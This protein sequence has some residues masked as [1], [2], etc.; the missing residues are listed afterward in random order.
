MQNDHNLLAILGPTNTG[1]TYLAFERLIAYQSG[2]FG[3]PLR[4]L[5][6]ENYDK[7]VAR[8]GIHKVALIT[9]EEKILPKEAKYYFCTVESMPLNI[10]VECIAIDEVQLAADYERGHIFTDRILHLR[11]TYETMLL[12][13]TTIQ[14]I[15]LRLF[16]NIKIENR[17]RFSRLSFSPKRNLSK[18]KPRSAVIAF[19][20]NNIYEIAETLRKHKGGAAVV[21]GSLSP[22]TR[23]AQVEIYEDKKVDYLVATDAIGMGLNLNIDHVAFTSFAKFD[24]RYARGLSPAEIGQIAGRAGRYLNDGNFGI[25]GDCKE[26]NAEEVELLENHKFEEIKT[27]VWRNSDLNFNN[28]S[29]LIKS[30]EE[31]PNKDWLRRVHECEDEKVLKYFL[32]DLSAHKISDNKQVLSLL[33]ECCQIPDFVKKTYGHHLEV[34]SKIFGFLNGKEKKVTNTY[35]KQQLSVLNK[36]EGNVDSLSN[37]IANVRTWS[38]VSNKVNWVENQDY[39]V[40]RT[41]LLEDK[42]SDRLHEELTKSF[43]DKRAN[44]LAR[45]LKQDMTFNT[46]II[47]DD[48]VIIDNQ[49]IGKLKGLKLELD[50]KVDTLDTDIKSLKKAARLSIGP[51]LNKRI[52][53][54]IDT[55]SLEIKDDFKIYW[56][57]FPIAKLLPGKDYLDPELS[58]IIDDIIEVAEQK[59][60]QEYLEKWLKE[61]INFVLKSLI[62]LRSL[63]ESNSSIRALAYQL[64]ENNGVLKRDKVSEYLKKLGQ[65]ERKILRNLGVKF[66]RY[67]V[68]L[69][70]LLKPEAVSLRIL[71]WKNYHQKSFNLKP[72]TFGLNFLEN[73]DFK[74]KNFMLLCGFENFDKYFVRIDIL[75]RLFV[76]II[77]SNEGK[78]TEIKLIP[79]MLNL[80]GCSKDNFLKLMQKMNYKTYQKEEGLYFKYLPMKNKTF[81]QMSTNIKKSLKTH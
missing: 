78:K 37:R 19:N 72:P 27:L 81:K 56:G 28:A 1:K 75:E 4:L 2:V 65:D 70:K 55:S 32:K 23:N 44:I 79:E 18:L 63:K 22:R 9:G 67:H 49:F 43:I 58:L 25:T 77:N 14:K 38:Y 17:E 73:K 74:N 5:A 15:L 34:V 10:E 76:Q 13:S 30:L 69:F 11:G 54:I 42:L 36:L 24:G 60:L 26:I 71:L 61:K 20:I 64:Y 45:G 33:W 29:S 68:F 48:K 21:L 40:E 62:D 7:A 3:F 12:G 50:L 47:E 80:L 59:K 39:W 66:G 46:E 8:L 6:R 52:K 53:Q 41:K 57:K 16:P 51:E 35:M 31:R